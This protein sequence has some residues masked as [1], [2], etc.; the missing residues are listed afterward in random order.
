MFY[1]FFLPQVKRNAMI[2]N[3]RGIYQ[4]PHNLLNGM[5]AAGGA[6]VLT[7]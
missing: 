5:F 4:L 2:C 3:K 7:Q 6:F 1:F